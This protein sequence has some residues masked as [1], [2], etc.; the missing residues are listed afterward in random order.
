MK[1]FILQKNGQLLL[2]KPLRKVWKD[3]EWGISTGPWRMGRLSTSKGVMDGRIFQEED[4]AR[5][6]DFR[7][8]N[9]EHSWRDLND[10]IWMQ[11]N[12]VVRSKI[13]ESSECQTHWIFQGQTFIYSDR[14]LLPSSL[15]FLYLLD[16][17]QISMAMI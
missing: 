13:P 15:E 12:E 8:K 5:L 11:E 14:E 4:I 10:P 7:M 6:M 16:A 9:R 2:I 1:T 17:G 3:R